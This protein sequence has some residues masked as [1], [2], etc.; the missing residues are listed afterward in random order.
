MQAQ[1]SARCM[2]RT[3]AI[4]RWISAACSRSLS[5]FPFRPASL[6]QLLPSGAVYGSHC[7]LALTLLVP[8]FLWRTSC[9]K[10]RGCQGFADTALPK[11]VHTRLVLPTVLWLG[12]AGE[13]CQGCSCAAFRALLG[14][15]CYLCVLVSTLA[16][17]RV[18][19]SLNCP[20]EGAKGGNI[21]ARY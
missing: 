21:R 8:S 20:Q 7:L 12:R 10:S 3:V 6:S 2:S 16:R 15:L 18:L 5:P 1:W 9:D 19:C 13:N 11:K 14:S 17:T 4:P